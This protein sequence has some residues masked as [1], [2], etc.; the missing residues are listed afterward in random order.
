MADEVCGSVVVEAGVAMGMGDWKVGLEQ[1]AMGSKERLTVNLK[2]GYRRRDRGLWSLLWFGRHTLRGSRLILLQL[3]PFC[4]ELANP[5]PRLQLGDLP[6]SFALEL[7][8]V[9]WTPRCLT[10][11]TS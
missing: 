5:A 1:A 10:S 4:L 8:A 7:I 11:T 2:R 3:S 9:Q 6:V